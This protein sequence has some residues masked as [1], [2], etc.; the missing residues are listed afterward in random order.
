MNLPPLASPAGVLLEF[1]TGCLFLHAAMGKILRPEPVLGALGALGVPKRRRLL[2]ALIGFEGVLGVALCGGWRL[3]VTVPLALIALAVFTAALVALRLRGYQGDCGCVGVST[4]LS[5]PPELRNVVL[6]AVL[7]TTV[8]ARGGVEPPL[9]AGTRSML[10]AA[11]LVAVA[12]ASIL[13][14]ARRDR[15]LAELWEV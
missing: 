8:V 11:A 9:R 6:I 5:I 12:A 2:P 14:E 3:E 15:V 7:G 13:L 10:A 4:L 1:A